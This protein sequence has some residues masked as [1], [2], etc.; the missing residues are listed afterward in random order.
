MYQQGVNN[1]YD[2]VWTTREENGVTTTLTYGDV[3]HQNEVEQS[4][5]NFEY[6]D[7]ETLLRHFSDYEAARNA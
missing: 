3:Y 5:Y 4:T 6:S 1:V 7:V 2:L